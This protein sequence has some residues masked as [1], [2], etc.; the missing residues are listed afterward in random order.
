MT[1]R[2]RLVTL[3]PDGLDT[4]GFP[5]SV[6]F[7]SESLHELNRSDRSFE[8]KASRLLAAKFLVQSFL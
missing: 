5:E 4:F 8:K 1:F 6:S 2:D 3:T 7:D